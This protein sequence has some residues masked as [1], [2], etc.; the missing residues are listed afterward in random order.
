VT[1]GARAKAEFLATVLGQLAEADDVGA[2]CFLETFSGRNISF[3]DRLDFKVV[4]THKEPVTGS[5][6]FVMERAPDKS[7]ERTRGK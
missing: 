1:Q 7:R 4:A 2:A 5:E 6:Y 3:Y